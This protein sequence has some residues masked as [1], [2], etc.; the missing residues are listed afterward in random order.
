M[1]EGW[2]GGGNEKD[3]FNYTVNMSNSAGYQSA[4]LVKIPSASAGD[5]REEGSVTGVLYRYNLAMY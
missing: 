3:Y 1:R 2:C 4:E 5:A